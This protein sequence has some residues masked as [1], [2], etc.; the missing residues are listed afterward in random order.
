[1]PASTARKVCFFIRVTPAGNVVEEK[2][3]AENYIV[4]IGAAA[5]AKTERDVKIS[6]SFIEDA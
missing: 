1:M 6:M 4:V 5:P 3:A 2:T